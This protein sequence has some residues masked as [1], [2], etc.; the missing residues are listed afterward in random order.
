MAFDLA[1]GNFQVEPFDD[2]EGSQLLLKLSGV[3]D[4]SDSNQDSAQ[5]IS[6]TLGGLPFSLGSNRGFHPAAENRLTRLPAAL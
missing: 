5:A 1:K 2:T 6:H 4:P 3:K